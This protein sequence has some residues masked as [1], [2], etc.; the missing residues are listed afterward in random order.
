MTIS[1][2]A[3][4]EVRA[5]IVAER[6]KRQASNVRQRN[7]F[8]VGITG[9]QGSGKSFWASSLASTLRKH[10]GLKVI[11]V[12]L[13]DFY[14]AHADLVKVRQSNCRNALLR[15]RGQPGT[16]DIALVLRFFESLRS[17]A[18]HIKVPSF[19]K[20]KFGGEGDRVPEDQWA[21]VPA[22][23]PIDVVIFEGWCIGFQ[24]LATD[25]LQRVW[26]AAQVRT[27]PK[28]TTSEEYIVNTLP[29]YDFEDLKI[30]NDALQSYNETFMGQGDFDVMV[31]LDTDDLRNV[32]QWRMQQEEELLRKTGQGMTQQG[33]V[34]FVR[35]YM[36]SYE[37]Y[38]E[39][40]RKEKFTTAVDFGSHIRVVIDSR[41]QVL[42]IDERK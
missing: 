16:H 42:S 39:R 12:S 13:D 27:E 36:V 31:H 41:R 40:L 10:D 1:E 15:M 38:L 6:K 32:Y 9:L 17:T 14:Y 35:G 2:H 3:I 18:G 19:D 8:V 34:N 5:R 25:E 29:L 22:D 21:I 33:V 26:Q 37:L 24:A 20:S 11:D 28:P 23:P 7:V 30:V 4:H